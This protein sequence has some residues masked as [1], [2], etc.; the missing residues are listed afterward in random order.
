MSIIKVGLQESY[1]IVSPNK[2]FFLRRYHE[3]DGNQ[4]PGE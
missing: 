3:Q 1:Q 2:P 4:S